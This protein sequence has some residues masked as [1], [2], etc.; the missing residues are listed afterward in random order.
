MSTTILVAVLLAIAGFSLVAAMTGW[1][2]A[3]PLHAAYL[4]LGVIVLEA[5]NLPLSINYGIWLY[6]EDLFFAMLALA[7][8]GRF[9]L[10]ASPRTVP[11]TWWVIGAVQLLL[12]V[13]GYRMFGSRAGVDCRVHFYLW[14]SVCYFC[15][16]EWSEEMVKRVLD[17]WILCALA[18][19][20]LTS[21]RWIGSELDP[22]Y[23]QEIMGRDTTGVRFRV[24]SA[25][26]ALAIAI[27]FLI[28]LF[29][30]LNGRLPLRQRILLPVFFLTVIILQH[31]SVW[32]SLFVG[33]VCLLWTGQ[34]ETDRFRSALGIGMLMLPL[35]LVFAIPGDGNSVVTSIKTAAGSA[36][37]TKEGTMV[38]RMEN[39]QELLIN[40]STAKNPVTYL[41]GMPYGGGYNP[42]ESE[43]GEDVLDMVPH[44]HFVHIL[45][46]G[47]LIALIATVTLFYQLMAAAIRLA[48][49][50]T[51]PAAPCFVAI[52]GAL[53]AYF[54]PYWA[55]YG[56]GI[57]MGIAVSYLG[58]RDSQ[59]KRSPRVQPAYQIR[60]R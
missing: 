48:K 43:D 44:N 2:A 8:L 11:G 31:R 40:W 54:I 47:G 26:A 25:S 15:S 58:L 13:W 17:G 52:F 34:Q 42:M 9:S 49:H 36:V 41:V 30:M 50:G 51:K 35:A 55:T 28:L 7:C 56:S 19:C 33:A 46:R 45:Y 24:V 1:L 6:P 57:L 3:K 39:W 22:E 4:G 32:V 60:S 12:L 29:R 18:L 27:G 53:L 38:A 21:Y 59:V 16:V 5:S 20:M 10:F 14:V 37:S 23:A